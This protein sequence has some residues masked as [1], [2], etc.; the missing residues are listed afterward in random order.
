ME[1][2]AFRVEFPLQIVRV[3][4]MCE[5]AHN[6]LDG[7]ASGHDRAHPDSGPPTLTG[8]RDSP[9]LYYTTRV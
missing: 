5:T 3:L 4:F 1:T 6:L 2:E 8:A 7:S 9:S